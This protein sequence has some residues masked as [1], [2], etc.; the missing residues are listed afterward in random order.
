M[1]TPVLLLITLLLIQALTSCR[2]SVPPVVKEPDVIVAG[3]PSYQGL[4]E[5]FKLYNYQLDHLDD[6]VPR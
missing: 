6:G 3:A 5:T 2:E 1:K 4:Q